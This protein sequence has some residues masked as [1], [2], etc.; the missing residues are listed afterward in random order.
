MLYCMPVIII[1]TA[2]S[3]VQ[4]DPFKRPLPRGSELP[5]LVLDILDAA[6]LLHRLDPDM[7]AP[8]T[9]TCVVVGVFHNV[10]LLLLLVSSIYFI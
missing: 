2:S 9:S 1:A 3:S 4:R 7:P 8:R 10:V 5:P 6:V